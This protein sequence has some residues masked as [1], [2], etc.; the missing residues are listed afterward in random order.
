M[1]QC[2]RLEE[3]WYQKWLMLLD[4]LLTW[5]FISNFTKNISY[6]RPWNQLQTLWIF[7]LVVWCPFDSGLF[8]SEGMLKE[9]LQEIQVHLT[10]WLSWTPKEVAK[11]LR[12]LVFGGG[13]VNFVLWRSNLKQSFTESIV[14]FRVPFTTCGCS[15]TDEWGPQLTQLMEVTKYDLV[16]HPTY[17]N[18][19]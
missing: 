5:I 4:V 17:Y 8:G 11:Q 18:I 7:A 10:L 13:F 3:N 9:E 2:S 15:S 14:V 1:E 19:L 12:S 16:V 6:E